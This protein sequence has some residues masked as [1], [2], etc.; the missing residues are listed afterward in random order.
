MQLTLARKLDNVQRNTVSSKRLIPSVLLA[1]P[2]TSTFRFELEP[3]TGG[4][5]DVNGIDR[6]PEG[7]GGSESLRLGASDS[8]CTSGGEIVTFGAAMFAAMKCS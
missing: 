2:Q 3:D 8:N 4:L 7:A 1:T 5:L 6:S